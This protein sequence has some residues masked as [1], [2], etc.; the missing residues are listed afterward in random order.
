[1]NDSKVRIP[2]HSPQRRYKKKSEKCKKEVKKK[3]R[4]IAA[5]AKSTLCTHFK[6]V[7]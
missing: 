4:K 2:V 7:I 6:K 3:L 1:M 5:K